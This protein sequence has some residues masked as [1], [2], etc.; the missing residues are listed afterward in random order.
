MPKCRTLK[1]RVNTT[2]K[3][4]WVGGKFPSTVV[5]CSLSL[6]GCYGEEVTQ[7]SYFYPTRRIIWYSGHFWTSLGWP[8]VTTRFAKS[9]R[10]QTGQMCSAFFDGLIEM[11]ANMSGFREAHLQ[12]PW[13]EYHFPFGK[14]PNSE[15]NSDG[16]EPT[17]PSPPQADHWT[18]T[19][20]LWLSL[21][22]F[23]MLPCRSWTNF[24]PH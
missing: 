14:K 24:I 12:G 9:C 13:E 18:P 8:P 16:A 2:H 11:E 10:F 21:D 3:R 1:Y 20:C 7:H 23:M 17:W 22:Y 4:W 5:W 15:F 6:R 19:A